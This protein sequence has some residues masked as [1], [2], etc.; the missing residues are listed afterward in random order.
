KMIYNE[1]KDKTEKKL[2][3]KGVVY[4]GTD[5]CCDKKRWDKNID[6]LVEFERKTPFL[7]WKKEDEVMIKV[8][9][10]RF[11][12]VGN[13]R[14]KM[15]KYL[16]SKLGEEEARNYNVFECTNNAVSN[17]MRRLDLSGHGW[18]DVTKHRPAKHK[19]STSVF[20]V[21]VEYSDIIVRDDLEKQNAPFVTMSVD[22][23]MLSFKGD[24]P[25]AIDS[26]VGTFSFDV[27]EN[28]KVISKVVFIWGEAVPNYIN[29]DY[30]IRCY[31]FEAQ[32]FHGMWRYIKEIDPDCI[33]GWNSSDFDLPYLLD[34]AKILGLTFFPYLTRIK[35]KPLA[36]FQ[37]S[38]FS[39]QQKEKL[40]WMYVCDGVTIMDGLRIV[41][42]DFSIRLP[43]Y[44]LNAVA[45]NI[46]KESKEMMPYNQIVPFFKGTPEQRAYLLKYN[47]VDSVLVSEI[48][49]KRNLIS[50]LIEQSKS[51]RVLLRDLLDRGMT[52]RIARV[53]H[54][55]ASKQ[56]MVIATHRRKRIFNENIE[57]HQEVPDNPF[58]DK[59]KGPHNNI[60]I[61]EEYRQEQALKKQKLES[62][63]QKPVEPIPLR[64]QFPNNDYTDVDEK[65]YTQALETYTKELKL[66][67]AY[68]KSEKKNKKNNKNKNT[69]S[70]RTFFKSTPRN[71][72]TNASI[73]VN[74]ILRNKLKD[75]IKE[76]SNVRK[77]QTTYVGAYVFTPKPGTHN[78]VLT[79]DFQAMYP[80]LIVAFN[81]CFSTLVSSIEEA[82][83][84]GLDPDKDLNITPVGYMFVKQ[85]VRKGVIPKMLEDLLKK[86]YAIKAEMKNVKARMKEVDEEEKKLLALMYDIMNGAQNAAKICV[87][88]VYGATGAPSGEIY[89]PMIGASTT[90]YGRVDIQKAAKFIERPEYAH[91][92]PEVVYGDTD[93]IMV[94]VNIKDPQEAIRVGIK[95]AEDMN[96]AKLFLPPM[97]MEF[98]CVYHPYMI[99]E[100]KKRYC[101]MMYE[102]GK[103]EPKV[104]MSGIEAARNDRCPYLKQKQ[105]DLFQ[106][107]LNQYI[108]KKISKQAIFDFVYDMVSD[109]LMGKVPIEDLTISQKLSKSMDDYDSVLPHI[110][111]AKI[112][113]EHNPVTAPQAG[114]ESCFVFA[115]QPPGKKIEKK[116]ERAYPVEFMQEHN[117]QIDFEF[118]VTDHF[119]KPFCRA[120]QFMLDKEDIAKLFDLRRYPKFKYGSVS[121]FS[122]TSDTIIPPKIKWDE[123]H[124]AGLVENL[125]KIW[126]DT[127]K[128]DEQLDKED[129]GDQKAKHPL[130]LQNWLSQSNALPTM[131]VGAY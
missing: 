110:A 48:F 91:L 56:N 113:R 80:S 64:L 104:K 9:L 92:E 33:I 31:K 114:G 95:I 2:V 81:M 96:T 57:Q 111:A 83:A 71:A 37:K 130:W 105:T 17:T 118:Y 75:K 52:F 112:H 36:R 79:F 124:I 78:M 12:H 82:V 60:Y 87:N 14:N 120:L 10:Q 74:T 121:M 45:N 69:P 68:K 65:A 89:C 90:A 122:K 46:L 88:S 54:S 43:S 25:K 13:V 41:R 3:K 131:E 102:E 40:E 35:Y 26:P 16:I 67:N 5:P 125:V 70:I 55:N 53:I 116:S 107:F 22:G 30:E 15:W 126:K 106:L 93:S 115:T 1:K 63:P 128:D 39:N 123:P 21:E 72:K 84:M 38:S 108:E 58:Y 129:V 103:S 76:K 19:M 18:V 42:K 98:E 32:M 6:V 11:Y 51:C 23:E 100:S 109:I 86:R 62:T 127:A 85:H 47:M 119:M 7:G 66:Y 20:E 29:Q 94:S 44:S 61:N 101:C 97:N 27:H 59:I 99:W 24:F 117:R 50:N 34:R 49:A 4:I 77:K 8:S 28:D 73:P